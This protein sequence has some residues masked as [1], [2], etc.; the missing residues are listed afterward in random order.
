MRKF[1]ICVN[2]LSGFNLISTL[3]SVGLAEGIE[4]V[5]MPCRALTSFLPLADY[6]EFAKLDGV[7]ALSGFNL[8]STLTKSSPVFMRAT[9]GVFTY[10]YQNILIISIFRPFF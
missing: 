6:L 9:E 7:N 1:L 8:I 5:S 4:I 10:N 3:I 2:A